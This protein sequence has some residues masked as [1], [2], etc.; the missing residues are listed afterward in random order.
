MF[1]FSKITL[2]V[3]RKRKYRAMF[4]QRK[5]KN[6]CVRCFGKKNPYVFELSVLNYSLIKLQY[7]H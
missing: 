4:A 6:M 7:S 3:L 5:K 2:I 1:K